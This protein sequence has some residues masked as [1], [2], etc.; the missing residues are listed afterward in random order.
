MRGRKVN[1][2]V[3]AIRRPGCR[4]R[5]IG[6]VYGLPLPHCHLDRSGW[7]FPL[8]ANASAGR[9]VEGSASPSPAGKIFLE[10]PWLYGGSPTRRA[11]AC[12][13]RAICGTRL[14]ALPFPFEVGKGMS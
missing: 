10:Y 13:L 5:P 9:V 7:P 6:K 11:Q 3:A 4:L 14:Q 8:L 1:S 2:H 12:E